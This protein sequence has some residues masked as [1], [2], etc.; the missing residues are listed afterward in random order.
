MSSDNLEEAPAVAPT[1]ALEAVHDDALDVPAVDHVQN[2]Y[3]A[4]AEYE[5]FVWDNL[6]R[7]YAGHYLH[8]MLGMTGFRLFN[9]PTFL[10]AYLHTLT[11]S[12]FLI[13]LGMGLQQAG[14]VI[15]P[16]FG[17]AQIEHRKKVLPA[18][19]LIGSGM[20]LPILGVALAGWLLSGSP[21]LLLWTIIGLLFVF[22]IFSGAQGVAFQVLL[23]KVVPISRRGR[24]QAWRNVT[25]GIVAVAL[26]WAAG[27]YLVG[28]NYLGYGYPLTF[29][30]AFV[31]TSA[32]LT[33]LRLLMR[34]PIP[35]TTRPRATVRE[36]I[37]DFPA[38]IMGDR[39]FMWFMVA[40]VLSSG[41][42]IA[43]TFYTLSSI[44][45]L[46][47]TGETIGLF[48]SANL[49]GDIATN[50]IWGYLG[51]KFGF[52]VTFI[53]ALILWV[54]AGVLMIFAGT[55]PAFMIAFFLV[56]AAQSGQQ[57]S[58]STMVLEFGTRDDMPMRLA[59]TQTAQ[60]S[61]RAL[62]PLIG[63]VIGQFA[64]YVPVFGLAI[65]FQI[66]ALAVLVGVV[67]EPRTAR[68]AAV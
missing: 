57:T 2:L 65:V 67:K 31:L 55:V 26:A 51:D 13:G 62:G 68:M 50:L 35:P 27:K 43:L 6:R 28:Q 59:L 10:P 40:Q 47:V 39:N 54:I 7:N 64:G 60:G 24:L 5:K 38:L 18:A 4:E 44:Q 11:G 41:G 22:G 23:A 19:T 66:I 34:E 14:G 58:S 8:G 21:Q 3:A 36:R 49:A 17:A 48:T 42:T 37:K 52:R 30:L 12:S 9:T 16:I 46:H 32:G 33:A 15:S 53:G 29:L 45:K 56:G 1:E 63:G 20:R 25:G 61:M